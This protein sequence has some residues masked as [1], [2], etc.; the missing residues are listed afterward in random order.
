VV[1][2]PG[3]LER[4]RPQRLV[5][6]FAMAFVALVLAF[7]ACVQIDYVV[8]DSA[9]TSAISRVAAAAIVGLMSLAG[10]VVERSGQ[11]IIYHAASF[12]ILSDC[13]GI[14]VMGLFAAAVIAFP[15]RWRPRL[16]VLGFGLPILLV[17]N[18]VRMISLIYVGAHWPMALSYGHL[19]V[20]P[21]VL[22]TVALG[23]W[24]Q[25]ALRVTNDLRV[26][27]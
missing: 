1:R 9:A 24:L 25:W 23:I 26:V 8:F 11:V 14:E 5:L 19:Y 2:M 17:L 20:W 21:V 16:T 6:R 7:S 12:E 4:K 13:T 22:L 18:V 10:A 3:V 27:P 15:C